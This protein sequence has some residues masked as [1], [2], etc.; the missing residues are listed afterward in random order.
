M[1]SI[2]QPHHVHPRLSTSDNTPGKWNLHLGETVTLTIKPQSVAPAALCA[3]TKFAGHTVRI[4]MTT[5]AP[6]PILLAFVTSMVLPYLYAWSAM[7][8]LN[9]REGM[10]LAAANCPY[11]FNLG[12]SAG[13]SH[14]ETTQG[15]HQGNPEPM[16][17][18]ETGHLDSPP[19]S[20]A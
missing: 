16:A 11:T 17:K 5:P 4:A 8:T 7:W 12:I 10:C 15:Q 20:M 1:H 13:S 6:G 3:L 19:E 9:S 18:V 2:P 14:S